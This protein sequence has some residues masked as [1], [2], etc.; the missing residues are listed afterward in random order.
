MYLSHYGLQLDAMETL[1]R[2]WPECGGAQSKTSC[3]LTTNFVLRI[4]M[5]AVLFYK[6][7][8]VEDFPEILSS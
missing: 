5:S 1:T 2:V 6:T 8:H 4:K 7:F 3:Q